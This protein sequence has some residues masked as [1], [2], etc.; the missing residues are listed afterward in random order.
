M[1]RLFR[2]IDMKNII[3]I[4]GHDKKNKNG[5]IKFVLPAN[6]GSIL[7]DIEAE[8]EIIKKSILSMINTL[9]Y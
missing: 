6:I 5:K 4:M 3:E 7:L 8:K 1:P 9:T 2:N